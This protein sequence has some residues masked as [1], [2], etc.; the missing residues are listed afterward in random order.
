MTTVGEFL[1]KEAVSWQAFDEQVARIAV[2][3]RE[4]P[5]V[6]GDWTVK[7]V[8]WHCAYWTRFA[9]DHL[10]MEGVDETDGPFADP[11]DAHPD[12]HWDALNQRIAEA[13]SAMS[14]DDV[15]AGAEEARASL[16]TAVARPGLA[17]E[18]IVWA[19]DE[20]WIHYDEHA[21]HVRAF[22]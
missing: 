14:W 21:Q 9:A 16:R 12:E 17:A 10:T 3:R 7:D 2:D 4:T 8:V 22:S 13:S 20:S 15:V 1:D 19:A 6:V 11:F 5:G 18:A